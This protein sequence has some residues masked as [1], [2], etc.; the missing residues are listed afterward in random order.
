M[1]AKG[2]DHFYARLPPS[3]Q[4]RQPTQKATS[5][6]EGSAQVPAMKDA[7]VEL[8]EVLPMAEMV[9][10][11][12]AVAREPVVLSLSVPSASKSV[13]LSTHSVSESSSPSVKTATTRLLPT[14]AATFP[15]HYT[16]RTRS[17]NS[18]Y[19]PLQPVSRPNE[20]Q[21]DLHCEQNSYQNL[22]TSCSRSASL[23]PWKIAREVC[24]SQTRCGLVGSNT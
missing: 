6:D 9:D 8:E 14:S 5:C 4:I 11:A 12:V 21:Q 16:Q 18:R 10:V 23:R 2:W 13:T 17:Q 7:L 20:P 24:Y 3:A 1:K 15:K 19:R 22:Y